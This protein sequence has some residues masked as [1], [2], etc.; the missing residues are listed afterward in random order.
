MFSMTYEQKVEYM[1]NSY[2]S[3]N[4]DYYKGVVDLL[5]RVGYTTFYSQIL[6]R[7]DAGSI[8]TDFNL[9]EKAIIHV[10]TPR[11][12]FPTK[13]AL[14]DSAITTAL[15]GIKINDQT[16]IGVGYVAEA[17]VDFGFPG[18]LA[19]LW[20]IGV[21]LGTAA[22][23]FMTRPVSLR[24][25]QAFTVATL[26]NCFSFAANIDKE[27]GGF[28]TAFLAMAIAL[29]FGYP[30]IEPWLLGLPLRRGPYAVRPSR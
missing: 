11:V 16:S 22:E 19:P 25:R 9:Y 10:V 15:L 30:I 1:A 4:L 12:L 27:F 2:L 18:L 3:G 28:V 26:F 24:I 29:K 8:G 23:Y 6:A 14:N 20:I 13:A 5:K 17:Q 7:Q 21:L